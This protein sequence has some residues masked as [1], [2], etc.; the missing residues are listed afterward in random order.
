MIGGELYILQ[1]FSRA[2]SLCQKY[3]LLSTMVVD[4]LEVLIDGIRK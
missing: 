3:L 4:L 2:E 1:T